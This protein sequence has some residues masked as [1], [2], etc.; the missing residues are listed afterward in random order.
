MGPMLGSQHLS[1]VAEEVLMVLEVE[2][3]PEFPSDS[4]HLSL[5]KLLEVKR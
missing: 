4:E 2:L 3:R 1:K 5:P